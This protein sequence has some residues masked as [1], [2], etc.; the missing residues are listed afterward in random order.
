MNMMKQA[1]IDEPR[2]TAYSKSQREKKRQQLPD[3]DVVEIRGAKMLHS[4]F[5]KGD[6]RQLKELRRPASADPG[7]QMRKQ[8]REKEKRMSVH[9]NMPTEFGDGVLNSSQ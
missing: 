6:Q 8:I 5:M 4:E 3:K 7:D 2:I 9:T 1:S